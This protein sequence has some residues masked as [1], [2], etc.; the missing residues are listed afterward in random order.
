MFRSAENQGRSMMG[1]HSDLN[2]STSQGKYV[3][4]CILRKDGDYYVEGS[5]SD[6]KQQD[7]FNQLQVCLLHL[8]HSWYKC[9][10]FSVV[11]VMI[12]GLIFYLLQAKC[13]YWGTTTSDFSDSHRSS[14]TLGWCI[15]EMAQDISEAEYQ[16]RVSPVREEM[17]G[18]L[19]F[20]WASFSPFKTIA[21]CY[22]LSKLCGWVIT[23]LLACFHTHIFNDISHTELFVAV[24]R[25][26][27]G[28]H[29]L[30]CIMR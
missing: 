6:L 24:N 4:R 19:M 9:T 10:L 14:S 21:R 1:Q 29:P 2:C 13:K 16:V 26:D 11:Q 15:L 25:F 20:R 5:C 30:Y 3:W 22:K 28:S 7:R 12:S 27:N 23:L 17:N 8:C 18:M